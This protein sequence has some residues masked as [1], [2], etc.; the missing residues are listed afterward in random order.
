METE[1]EF[2]FLLWE[3]YGQDSD[4]QHRK[5][6]WVI[7]SLENQNDTG[8]GDCCM[9]VLGTLSPKVILKDLSS[10]EGA[11]MFPS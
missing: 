7:G 1:L 8:Q 4:P 5:P 11:S 10:D 6:Q 9:P 3:Q 2:W